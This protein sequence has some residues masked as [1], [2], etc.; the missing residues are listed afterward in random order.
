MAERRIFYGMVFDGMAMDA[1][2][3][4]NI[5]NPLKCNL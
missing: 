2:I 1:D 5:I 4:F 3:I